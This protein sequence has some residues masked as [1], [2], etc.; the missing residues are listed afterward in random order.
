MNV[1][2][3]L[4]AIVLF[5]KVLLIAL[6]IVV[7]TPVLAEESASRPFWDRLFSEK[8]TLSTATKEWD[9]AHWHGQNFQRTID[10]HRAVKHQS[11]DP[12]Q[13]I[14]S[15]AG[16]IQTP[17]GLIDHLKKA[18]IIGRVYNPGVGPFWERKISSDVIIELGS[19]FYTL[20]YADQTMVTN[21]LS[22][23]FPNETYT[24][25]DAAT[26]KVV[27]QITSQGFFLY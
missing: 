12:S 26:D 17:Q 24:L 22:R 11:I 10:P 25:K 7:T 5:M 14:L 6:F 23:A 19:N 15:R 13:S 27:G 18:H 4:S 3:R 9:S 2:L 21:L 8:G 20:S 1:F 16:D